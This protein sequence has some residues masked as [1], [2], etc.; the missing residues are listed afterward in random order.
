MNKTFPEI[1]DIIRP[2]I[3]GVPVSSCIGDRKRSLASV[4]EEQVTPCFIALRC[5]VINLKSKTALLDKNMAYYTLQ[6]IAIGCLVL[7]AYLK[8]QEYID[9]SILDSLANTYAQKNAD[10]G[11]AFTK[12][13]NEMGIVS[14]YTRIADKYYRIENLIGTMS[15]VIQGLTCANYESLED[16]LLDTVN[17]AMM[18]VMVI[19]NEGIK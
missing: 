19:S 18:S 15:V 3:T 6:G 17:Y 10:Y 1:L 9:V 8:K 13:Y 14:A 12:V 7:Y 5:S 2:R 16:S 4:F 11:D